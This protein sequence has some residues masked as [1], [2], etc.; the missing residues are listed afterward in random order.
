MNTNTHEWER[1]AENRTKHG[2][3]KGEKGRTV[4]LTLTKDVR[5]RFLGT[6]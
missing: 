5:R 1:A 4:S 3:T 2:R 6:S